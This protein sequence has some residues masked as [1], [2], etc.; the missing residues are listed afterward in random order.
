MLSAVIFNALVIVA[1]IPL[2]L[3][4]VKFRPAGRRPSCAATCGSTGWAG[5]S[6]PSSSSSSS[7]SSS[8]RFT[9]TDGDHLMLVH[10][11]RSVI[12]VF[13]ALVLTFAYA[14]AGT[15]VS[16]RCS[17]TRLTGR[18]PPTAP[19]SSARTGRPPNARAI[20]SAAA[21]SRVVP[22]TSGPMPAQTLSPAEHPAGTTL[23]WP[24]AHPASRERPISDPAPRSW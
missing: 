4:G 14:Y 9:P 22:T 1:L 13:V 24:T 2:A 15:G 17:S 7:T 5:S 12:L 10:I 19:P 11:R 21:C 18:S 3:R 20:P 6:S 16:Q 8:S 23:W